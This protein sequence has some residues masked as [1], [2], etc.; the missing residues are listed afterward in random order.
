[1]PRRD[2]KPVSTNSCGIDLT[3][4]W[5]SGLQSSAGPIKPLLGLVG[6]SDPLVRVIPANTGHD[7]EA[8]QPT[9]GYKVNPAQ[10]CALTGFLPAGAEL[11]CNPYVCLAIRVDGDVAEWSKA[12]PC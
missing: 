3:K 8:L 5:T 7:G 12:L 11:P 4:V 2:Q 6:S 1:M 9:K 10:C